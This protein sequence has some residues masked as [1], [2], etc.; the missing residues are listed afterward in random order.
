M[1]MSRR[2]WLV[3]FVAAAAVLGMLVA[4]T[5]A[6]AAA[7]RVLAWSPTTSGGTYGYGTIDGVG[8]KTAT[9]TF[10][11]ANSGSATGTLAA[12]R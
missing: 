7:L 4:G 2:R 9:L 6:Q 1:E 11:L 3:P 8:G 10:T 5:S 12:A